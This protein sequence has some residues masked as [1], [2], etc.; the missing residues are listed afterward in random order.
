MGI[1]TRPLTDAGLDDAARLLAAR[2]RE[3]R[4]RHPLLTEDL[5][6]PGV[7]RRAL[8]EVLASPAASGRLALRDGRVAGF[9]AGITAISR[10]DSFFAYLAPPRSVTIPAIGHAVA[11]GEDPFA[12]LSRLYGDLA[13][14]WVPLGYF[15]HSVQVIPGEPAEEAWVALGFGRQASVAVRETAP[16]GEIRTLPGLEVRQ[17]TD[18]DLPV[19]VALARALGLHHTGAPMFSFWAVGPGSEALTRDFL[20][21]I[22]ADPANPHFVAYQS[23]EPVGMVTFMSPGFTPRFVERDRNLYLFMGIVDP[24]RRSDGL[25]RVLLDHGLAWAREHGY[26]HTTLHVLSANSSGAPFWFGHG[27]RP[28]EHTLARHIDERILWVRGEARDDR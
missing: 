6:E 23:G 28:I 20:R 7:A 24:S 8:A 22:L 10:F 13:G 3:N 17:A 18:E 5:E 15:D 14:G 21:P 25:G 1:E 27:F 2:H 26:T 19:V 11:P 12:V 16:L 4:R 9:L